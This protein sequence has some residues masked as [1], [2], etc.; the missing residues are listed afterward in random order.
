MLWC[1]LYQSL[2]FSRVKIQFIW[3]CESHLGCK[4]SKRFRP[5]NMYQELMA[6]CSLF[7]I[8]F[9]SHIYQ[10]KKRGGKFA[11]TLL[12]QYQR[13]WADFVAFQVVPGL[14]HS[15]VTVHILLSFMEYLY[16]GSQSKA[17]IAKFLAALRYFHMSMGWILTHFRI[18]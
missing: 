8:D 5:C 16:E 6:N 10:G 14:P 13:M 9:V 1:M 7:N 4:N 2:V 18:R 11:Y 12:K 17:T 3:K 15:Q